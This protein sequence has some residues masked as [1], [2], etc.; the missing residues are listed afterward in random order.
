ML[1]TAGVIALLGLV[2]F[3]TAAFWVDWW[4]FGSVGFRS[5]LVTRFLAQG[6]T[7]VVAAAVAGVFFAANWRSALRRPIRDA[8]GGGGGGRVAA[9]SRLLRVPLWLLT[10]VVAVGV[11]GAAAG[12][13]QTWLLWLNGRGFGYRDPLFGRDAGFY[14]F[15]LPALELLQ[16]GA[17]ALLG[18]TAVAVILLYV[19]RLGLDRIDPRGA[20]FAVRAHVLGLAA[21]LVLLA[22]V[23]FLLANARLMYARRENFSGPGYTDANVLRWGNFALALVCLVVAVLLIVNARRPLL[24]PLAAAAGVG[25]LAWLVLLVVLPGVVQQTVVEPNELTRERPFVGHNIAA[26]RA[27]LELDR[28]ETRDL[29]GQGE[30]TAEMLTPSSPTFDNIRLWDYR[31]V[32]ANFQAA[33]S[34]VPYYQFGDV[35]VDRYVVDG[36]LRQVL[37]SARELDIGGLQESARGWVGRHLIYT[38]G[39]GAVISPVSEAGPTGLPVYLAG[40]IPPEEAGPFALGQPEI[41]FGERG[42]DWVAVNTRQR[43]VSGISSEEVADPYTGAGRGTIALDNYLRR[44]MTTV[45]LADRRILF[46]GELTDESRIVLRRGIVERVEAI[47]PFFRYDPDPYPVIADG[48]IV[49]VLDAYSESDRFPGAT[50]FGDVNYARHPVKVTVD[51]YDGT[52]TFYRTAAADPIADAYGRAFGGLLTP[53]SEAPPAVA[54][55]F[56]YPERL[57]DIQA[58]AYAQYHVT[59]PDA[60]FNAENRWQVALE[61]QEGGDGGSRNEAP[62]RMESYYVTLPTPSAAEPAFGLVLP[63]T[64]VG[65]TNMTAWMAG[66]LTEGGDLRLG[67]YR[68]PR[69][70]SVPGPEQIENRIN[71]DPEISERITLLD[72]SGSRVILGN[73]LVVPVGQTVL[74]AQP[75]FLQ[76]TTGENALTEFRYVILATNS[77]TVIRPTLAEALAALAEG[78]GTVAAD[79]GQQPEPQPQPPVVDGAPPL[80]LP[81]ADAAAALAAFERGQAALATGDWGEYGEAQAELERVLRGLAEGGVL[82]GTPV[83]TPEVEG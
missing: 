24:R 43:E 18:A 49:W 36:R 50:R 82:A 53:I 54:A 71:T 40:A 30:P 42:G 83:A 46:S 37:V 63:F 60:F 13:W 80:E 47:A 19:L 29:T 5:V 77:R 38:H 68:F 3:T 21:G 57:F 20:P 10:V 31:V 4:W 56:R 14:V 81:T 51:A 6:A 66:S 16:R 33:Q 76:A 28:I 22:G 9:G 48:R 8:G 23:G 75:F 41:Y 35:D 62:S 67:V 52:V 27:A 39:Y 34:F 79:A 70:V 44:L 61:Q 7:F 64:P 58:D 45:A 12:S 73:L 55:H 2:L 65:R 74:F 15:A 32:R 59:S 17:L 1:I 25:V 26:T 72:A 69:Q 78:Q 11:G